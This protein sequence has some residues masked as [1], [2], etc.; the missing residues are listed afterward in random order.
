MNEFII[1]KYINKL[2]KQDIK[3]YI[4]KE[5]ISLKESEID[6][7]YYYIKNKSNTFLKGHHKEILEELKHKVTKNT[8]QKIL[9]LYE[10]YKN[11]I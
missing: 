9:E 11:K 8:Y 7:I 2:T 3:N 10:L 1:K 6:T 4:E 5:N